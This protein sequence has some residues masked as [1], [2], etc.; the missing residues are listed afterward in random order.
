MKKNAYALTLD[1]EGFN[2]LKSDFNPI[3]NALI[4]TMIGKEAEKGSVTIKLD[5]TLNNGHAPDLDTI[6]YAGEREIVSPKI[7]HTITSTF[8]IKEKRTGS[9][10]GDEYEM[11]WDKTCFVLRKIKD[12]QKSLFDKEEESEPE[13]GE[14]ETVNDSDA[15]EEGSL[16][17]FEYE[18][19][20]TEDED[21][22]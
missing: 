19:P 6:N 5:I 8:Q 15:A 16:N 20:D 11:F 2:A 12:A 14:A 1:G 3:F 22:V 4:E 17:D 21:D 13:N 10:G 18:Q 7:E 9:T